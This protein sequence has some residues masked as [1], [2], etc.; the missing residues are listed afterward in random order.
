MSLFEVTLLENITLGRKPLSTE[1]LL[2]VLNFVELQKEM[3]HFPDGLK[4]LVQYRSKN[5]SPSQ[6][7]QVLLARAL[8]AR[9]KLLIVDG[10]LHEI[11]SPQRETILSMNC[12]PECPWT[13]VIVTTDS[14]IKSFV[15]QSLSLH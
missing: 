11:S 3:E 4:T 10:G 7:I 1:D 13:M 8:I 6:T 2:W 15:Q 5:F 12:A 14:N 9:P